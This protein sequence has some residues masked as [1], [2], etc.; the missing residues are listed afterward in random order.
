MRLPQGITSG[1]KSTLAP[2]LKPQSPRETLGM[3][4]T[5]NE[6]PLPL[7]QMARELGV[8]VRWLRSEA[9]RGA[10]PHVKADRGLLFDKATVERLLVERAKREGVRRGI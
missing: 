6:R 2:T 9:E 7:T 4:D 1:L 5:S 3:N 10:L 8:S